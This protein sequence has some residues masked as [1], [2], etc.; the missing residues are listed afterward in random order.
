LE[1]DSGQI[2]RIFQNDGS[3]NYLPFP[4]SVILPWIKSRVTTKPG[5]I[6]PPAVSQDLVSC[7]IGG[8]FWTIASQF[9][10]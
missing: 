7:G 6:Y 4:D 9:P 1:V 2:L 3:L 10:E 8:G 5:S